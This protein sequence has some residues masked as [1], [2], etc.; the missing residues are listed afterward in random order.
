MCSFNEPLRIPQCGNDPRISRNSSSLEA[1]Y[2]V[3]WISFVSRHSSDIGMHPQSFSQH[4]HVRNDARIIRI[5]RIK[6]E[7]SARTC[8]GG[9]IKFISTLCKRG[10]HTRK[11]ISLRAPHMSKHRNLHALCSLF[12]FCRT[13][14]RAH[15]M[16]ERSGGLQC[17][18]CRSD[19]EK[20]DS[21]SLFP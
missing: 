7:E 8:V 10:C 3:I 11:H 9:K 16:R 15:F 2:L 20:M 17:A 21:P 6:G 18:D 1:L 4:L 13:V 5:H 12:E 19:C 14:E